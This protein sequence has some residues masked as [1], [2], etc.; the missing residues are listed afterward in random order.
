MLSPLSRI[1]DVWRI[2]LRRD[3]PHR[4]RSP[5]WRV[6]LPIFAGVP[7]RAYRGDAGRGVPGTPAQR[8][9]SVAP[10][11]PGGRGDLQ[12]GVAADERRRL[13][14]RI[15]AALEREPGA[16]AARLAY[17]A[18]SAGDDEALLRHATA[19]ARDRSGRCRARFIGRR[20]W[21]GSAWW[22]SKE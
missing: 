19:A 9:A 8:D 14:A 4:E 22:I 11:S 15:L 10:A 17:H 3:W 13:H 20:R 7:G 16:D 5:D 2:A 12:D 6:R 21:T 18:E 1:G